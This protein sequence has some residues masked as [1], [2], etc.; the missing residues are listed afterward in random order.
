MDVDAAL[1]DDLVTVVVPARNEE[2]AIEACLASI[3]GQDETSLQILVMDGKSTDRTRE[4]VTAIAA[5]DPRVELL[6]NPERIVSTALNRALAA[7]RG[8]WLVRIDAHATVPPDYVRR[9]VGHL[10]T[11][12]WGGVP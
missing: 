10:G 1:R 4:L 7:A 6:D 9:A 12:R 8:A 3:L 11:G 5:R 2:A